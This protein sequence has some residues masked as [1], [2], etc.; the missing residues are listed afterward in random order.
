MPLS[1]LQS[2]DV[3]LREAIGAIKKQAEASE[4]QADA[5]KETW[6]SPSV[7]VEIG[8]LIVGIIYSIFAALQWS[9]IGRQADIAQRAL[10]V[11]ERPYI[12]IGI[13]T[14]S[15]GENFSCSCPVMN[16]GRGLAFVIDSNWIFVI[17]G[18]RDRPSELFYDP[19][20]TVG[21]IGRAT[22]APNRHVFLT[23]R[24]DFS[25]REFDDL[26]NSRLYLHLFAY[27]DYRDVI[28]ERVLHHTEMGALM[29]FEQHIASYNVEAIYPPNHT[30]RE[31][32]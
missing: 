16:E 20:N 19:Q 25:E 15:V 12:S 26:K 22:I 21:R 5:Y 9:A 14:M 3:S 29:K 23:A 4:K 6:Y 24:H 31:D 2:S 10:T 11:A 28:N 8:L 32:T 30:Y 7:L 17:T 27:V 1:L 18:S 13:S